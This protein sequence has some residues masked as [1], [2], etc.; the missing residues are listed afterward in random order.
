MVSGKKKYT[1]LYDRTKCPILDQWQLAFK[2]AQLTRHRR[3]TYP[4]LAYILQLVLTRRSV[5][6]GHRH[7]AA[8]VFSRVGRLSAHPVPVVHD[9]LSVLPEP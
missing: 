9:G 3:S 5:P 6:S 4:S 7:A 1:D 2:S 8:V